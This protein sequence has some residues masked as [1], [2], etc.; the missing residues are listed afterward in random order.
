[1]AFLA[2]ISCREASPVDKRRW[3][4]IHKAG[5]LARLRLKDSPVWSIVAW[6]ERKARG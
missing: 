5:T 4:S 1:M 6:N 2:I 3:S